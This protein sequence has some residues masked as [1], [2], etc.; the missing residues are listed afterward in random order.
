MSTKLWESIEKELNLI[1]FKISPTT[2]K[3]TGKNFEYEHL[4]QDCFL[5]AIENG[6]TNWIDRWIEKFKDTKCITMGVLVTPAGVPSPFVNTAK[7]EITRNGIQNPTGSNDITEKITKDNMMTPTKR[8]LSKLLYHAY[9]KYRLGQIL[10]IFNLSPDYLSNDF[11]LEIFNA[12]CNFMNELWSI[13]VTSVTGL[14]TV[15]PNKSFIFF[16]SFPVIGPTFAKFCKTVKPNSPESY[17]KCFSFFFWLA[18]QINLTIP[19]ITTGMSAAG[20]VTAITVC[21]PFLALEPGDTPAFDIS[22]IGFGL[23][24]PTFDG[25]ELPSFDFEWN[26]FKGLPNLEFAFDLDFTLEMLGLPDITSLFENFELKWDLAIDF[27]FEFGDFTF[28]GLPEF[29]LKLPELDIDL[30]ILLSFFDKEIFDLF[31]D[32]EFGSL[33]DFDFDKILSDKYQLF[34]LINTAPFPIVSCSG[35]PDDI[36]DDIDA[37]K[38]PTH[39]AVTEAQILAAVDAFLNSNDIGDNNFLKNNYKKMLTPTKFKNFIEEIKDDKS[40]YTDNIHAKHVFEKS[41]EVFVG[42][43]KLKTSAINKF[44]RKF[45]NDRSGMLKHWR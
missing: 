4:S 45:V 25:F 3:P 35:K 38:V 41:L 10:D 5:L 24:F 27:P 31:I 44:N 7:T 12:A 6:L 37:I 15:N 36:D 26:G 23:D 33:L 34:D 17:F 14:Q 30:E 1:N 42:L 19:I 22:G 43:G 29:K 40:S 32:F 13:K 2:Y 8:R 18:F 21:P 20:T 11:G 9:N 39:G 16:P 28:A